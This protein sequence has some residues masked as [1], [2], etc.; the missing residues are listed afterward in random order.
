MNL[1]KIGA[2][3]SHYA[4]KVKGLLPKSSVKPL[5][6]EKLQAVE[7]I[8]AQGLKDAPVVHIGFSSK[9]TG[10]TFQSGATGFSSFGKAPDGV[11]FPTNQAPPKKIDLTQ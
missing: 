6:G 2:C 4:N 11:Q 8:I 7:K 5:A 1:S 10:D 3:A 9:N